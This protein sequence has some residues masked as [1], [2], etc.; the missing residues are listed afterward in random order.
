MMYYFLPLTLT[1]VAHL[2]LL[3]TTAP[4][5]RVL[6]SFLGRGSRWLSTSCRLLLVSELIVRCWLFSGRTGDW[7]LFLP[8]LRKNRRIESNLDLGLWLPALWGV[9][10]CAWLRLLVSDLGLCCRLRD[11]LLGVSADCTGARVV[12][13]EVTGR[14]RGWG[15]TVGYVPP[16]KEMPFICLA[17]L[18]CSGS[19]LLNIEFYCNIY[20]YITIN[21]LKH[22]Y[23][24][25]KLRTD[26]LHVNPVQCEIL[27]FNVLIQPLQWFLWERFVCLWYLP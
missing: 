26:I 19:P 20:Y 1:I 8:I 25:E 5:P 14:S 22:S 6:T 2:L 11:F 23:I 4:P 3:T 12:T 9:L 27:L 13:E 16:V 10:A 21:I 18:Q 15:E 7:F 24:W 17:V